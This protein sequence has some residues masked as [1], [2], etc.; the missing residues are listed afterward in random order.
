MNTAV[1][2]YY[3]KLRQENESSTDLFRPRF[4]GVAASDENVRWKLARVKLDILKQ[5]E[6]NLTVSA[7]CSSSNGRIN[8]LFSGEQSLIASSFYK[9]GNLKNYN[10][11]LKNE[12]LLIHLPQLVPRP[13]L[14]PDRRRT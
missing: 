3:N 11:Q 9:L 12:I 6:F 13:P 8:L 7:Q 14:P 10:Y 2:E 5:N 1:V 4:A